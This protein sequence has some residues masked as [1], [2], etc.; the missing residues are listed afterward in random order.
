M[1]QTFYEGQTAT[2]HSTGERLIRRGGKWVPLTNG[3]MAAPVSLGTPRDQEALQT[4]RDTSAK[5]LDT[6]Q[7]V[8]KFVGLNRKQGTGGIYSLNLPFVGNFGDMAAP[9]NNELSQMRAITARLTPA[10]HVPGSGNSSDLDAK[11]FKQSLPAIENP[12][13]VNANIAKDLQERSDRDAARTAF[14]DTWFAKRGNLLGMEQAFN[15]FWAKRQAGDPVANNLPGAVPRLPQ[16][17][18]GGWSISR[19]K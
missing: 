1:A 5:S 7:Q 12:G 11:T 16:Q 8:E 13:Q 19:V 15:Q 3:S 10:Q 17:T 14:A 9:F 2:N 6:A 18:S 4:L